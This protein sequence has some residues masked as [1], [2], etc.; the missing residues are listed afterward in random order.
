MGERVM[1]VAHL[2]EQLFPTLEGASMTRK[3]RQMSIKV[4]QKGFHQKNDRFWHLYKICLRM[5]EICAN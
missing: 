1:L 5:W 4:A 3:N 2:A